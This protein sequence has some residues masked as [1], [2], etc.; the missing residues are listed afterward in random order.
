MSD[1]VSCSLAGKQEGGG[2]R[3]V[4]EGARGKIVVPAVPLEASDQGLALNRHSP[5]PVS[6]LLP[7]P[8]LTP[9]NPDPGIIGVNHGIVRIFQTHSYHPHQ[10][11]HRPA[12]TKLF[13]R[14]PDRFARWAS[15]PSLSPPKSDHFKDNHQVLTSGRL[16]RSHSSLPSPPCLPQLVVG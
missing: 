2:R 15:I 6:R 12:I 9:S 8:S 10:Q 5:G 7:P 3:D 1:T 16:N 14:N 13:N 4:R 11:S